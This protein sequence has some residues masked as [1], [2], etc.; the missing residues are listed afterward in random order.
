MENSNLYVDHL[1]WCGLIALNMARRAGTVNSPAQENLFLCRW[2][3]TAEKKRLF[4]R[5]LANDIRWLLKEGREKGLLADLPG[6]LE[7]LWRASSGDLLEQNDLF[8]LQH[9]MHAITLTGIN[10]GVLNESEWEG[11]YAV[12]LSPTI[13]G[14]FIRKSDLDTGFGED[15]RQVKTLAVRITADIPAVD[16]LLARAGWQ[17]ESDTSVPLLHQLR[18]C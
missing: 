2:L 5:E 1:A 18:A 7:Y 6:K 11:R 12:K 3:A 8:R 16:A 17:R 10:Y 14:V 9:V 13:P 4:R 15:G